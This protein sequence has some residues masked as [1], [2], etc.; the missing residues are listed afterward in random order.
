MTALEQLAT[1][2]R[3][4]QVAYEKE[5]VANDYSNQ[6]MTRALEAQLD[7]ALAGADQADKLVEYLVEMR[8]LQQKYARRKHSA[9]KAKYLKAAAKADKILAHRAKQLELNLQTV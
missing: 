2:T 5:R 9:V 4:Y 6:G 1:K 3:S 8:L 7:E